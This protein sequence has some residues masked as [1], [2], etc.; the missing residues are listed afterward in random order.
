MH[1]SCI[2]HSLVASFAEL[3][4]RD[5]FNPL[6]RINV[7]HIPKYIYLLAYAST[8][9]SSDGTRKSKEQHDVDMKPLLQALK[10]SVAFCSSKTESLDIIN[11]ISELRDHL[12]FSIVAA[13]VV[14]WMLVIFT[15]QEFSITAYNLNNTTLFVALMKQIA[16][17]HES[18]RPSIL[19]LLNEC[20]DTSVELD[21]TIVLQ[22]KRMYLDAMLYLL[23]LGH[24][25]PILDVIASLFHS[26]DMS[27]VRFVMSKIFEAV[28][29]PF[30]SEFATRLLHLLQMDRARSAL[31]RLQDKQ[32]QEIEKFLS[33]I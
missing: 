29:P 26:I 30:S 19:G 10:K 21:A 16:F 4:V 5:L 28:Q 2:E 8:A 1:C 14:D 9:S 13:G 12:Q 31:R 33:M 32:R 25:M 17:L 23:K 20:F 22:L 3:F 15:D 24:V 18:L 11:A 6:K 27:L 7:S